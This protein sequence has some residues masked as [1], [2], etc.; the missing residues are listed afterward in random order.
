M[1]LTA[2]TSF[3]EKMEALGYDLETR[4]IDCEKIPYNEQIYQILG[5]EKSD[6]VHKIGRLRYI[7]GE[8]T[9]IHYSFVSE[10]TIP[11]IKDDG[12]KIQ[13]MFAYYRQHGYDE[14]S[15]RTSLLSITFPTASEQQLLGCKSMV[16]LI[17]V[18]SDCVDS[19]TGKVLEYT[20]TLYRSDK[21]KYDITMNS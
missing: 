17:L 18:E 14:F 1:H 15:N 3:T 16:P 9:A 11:Q 7:D 20:K 2:E 6:T 21:F 12:S 5:I 13:S 10:T 8:P 4:T 19:K